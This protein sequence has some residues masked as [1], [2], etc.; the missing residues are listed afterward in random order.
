MKM[1]VCVF[2][3]WACCASPFVGVCPLLLD[4]DEVGISVVVDVEMTIGISNECA[5]MLYGWPAA[6][7]TFVVCGMPGAPNMKF[8]IC[9]CCCCCAQGPA[10]MTMTTARTLWSCGKDH[11]A[12]S[13]IA[14]CRGFVRREITGIAGIIERWTKSLSEIW[15]CAGQ[16]PIDRF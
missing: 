9:C 12:T 10:G 6:A 3:I 7:I 11:R 16:T 14:Q 5:V 8:G 13:C 15:R 1:S 2:T 4:N